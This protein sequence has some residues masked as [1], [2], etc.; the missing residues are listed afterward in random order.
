VDYEFSFAPGHHQTGIIFDLRR[1]VPYPRSR[2]G[3]IYSDVEGAIMLEDGITS[4]ND[5]SISIG[6]VGT[7]P[8]D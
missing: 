4:S 7:G 8:V 3:P 1:K 2:F 6:F 5:L